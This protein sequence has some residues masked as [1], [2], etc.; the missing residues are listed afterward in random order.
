LIR[1]HREAKISRTRG[2]NISSIVMGSN[3]VLLVVVGIFLAD[4][5]NPISNARYFFGTAM[6]SVATAFGLFATRQRFRFTACGFLVGMLVI[7]PLADA[8]RVSREA[9]LKSANP[10]QLLMEGDYDSFAQLMN[11][12]LVAARD[13]IVPF[14]QLSGVLLFWVPRTLWAAKPIDTGPYIA[15]GRGYFATNLSAPLWIE[16]YLNGSWLLLA[17][18]M[19]ALGFGVHRWDTRLEAEL[20]LYRMPG[21][22]GCVLPFY[23]MILLRG[24]LLQAA[25]ILFCL[26]AFSAFVSQRK[27]VNAR[28]AG[29]VPEP[30]P[31]LGVERLRTDYVPA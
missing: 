24:S 3:T 15:E 22:L 16:F 6:L 21:L 19:F 12:Y 31:G 25:S 4:V 13:G 28:A 14:K 18:G 1:F 11:G 30:L 10:I 8:F 23:L 20:N 17:V 26:L 29:I 27:K 7:F 5:M 2:A 9:T